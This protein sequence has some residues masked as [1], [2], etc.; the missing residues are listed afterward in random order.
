MQGPPPCKH[1]SSSL[2]ETVVTA[3]R[4][5]LHAI[6]R[7]ATALPAESRAD[8]E[9]RN[10]F[11][12]EIA[13]ILARTV[14]AHQSLDHINHRR[15]LLT[16]V[17]RLWYLAPINRSKVCFVCLAHVTLPSRRGH[18][19]NARR[20][21]GRRRNIRCRSDEAAKGYGP[22]VPRRPRRAGS[23]AASNSERRISTSRLAARTEN[24]N[25]RAPLV[26]S[27]FK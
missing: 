25:M 19:A 6:A 10:E 5:E 17:K 13:P 12:F 11:V 9:R 2:D 23:I 1:A 15:P 8:T 24:V 3:W 21:S 7:T 18:S 22:A 27:P 26:L 4:S 14:A 20:E 16:L